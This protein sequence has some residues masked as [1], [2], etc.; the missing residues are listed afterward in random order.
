LLATFL[1]LAGRKVT[2]QT[3]TT[4]RMTEKEKEKEKMLRKI[5]NTGRK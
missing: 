4:R 5:Q 2:K 1:S 3:E